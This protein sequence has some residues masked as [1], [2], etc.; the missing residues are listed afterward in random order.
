MLRITDRGRKL[1]DGITRRDLLRVGGLSLAGLSLPQLLQNEARAATAAGPPLRRG[2]RARAKS[3]I[4]FFLEGGPSHIDL[5][6]MKPAAPVE[7]RGEF[8]P[9]R[10]TV[11]GLNVCEHLPML[12]QQMHRLALVRSVTHGITD[13]NAGTYFAMTGR[14][15]VD[16]SRLITADG[17]RNF[18]NYGGVLAKLRPIDQPLPAFVHLPEVMSNLNVDIAGQSAGF[19]GGAYDPFVA[20]DP[21]LS[22]Y[23]VPGMAPR[24]ELPLERIGQRGRLVQNVDRALAGLADG[25]SLD[26]MNVFYR[27]AYAMISSPEARRA[28]DLS[29]EP[30]RLRERYGVDRGSDRSLE[31]RQFGGLPQLGQ[32]TLMARRLIEAGVRLVTVTSGRRYCQAWDTHRDHF[33]LLKRS[34]CPYF[35]RAFSALLEDMAYRGMLEDT[36]VVAMGEFGRTPRLGY[37]TSGAGAARDGRDHWPY[38]YTVMFAGAGVPGGAIYGASDRTAAYPSRDPVTPEDITATI[39]EI[40]GIPADTEIRD[41]AQGQPHNLIRGQALRALLS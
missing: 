40:M 22:D 19:L 30:T 33:P 6:D 37:I 13:H 17:P 12:S 38:C 31:A 25:P 26:R 28:F 41:A 18:P 23:Q 27:Q 4:L 9:I 5:W 3:C 14:Y 10:S 24:A 15:P 36:L 7:I 1:C 16:G 34:L 21:S 20:G 11:P 39:Y 2:G 8:Q 35:D 29:Q 32:C